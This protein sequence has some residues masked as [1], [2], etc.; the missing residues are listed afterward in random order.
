MHVT[1]TSDVIT[2]K[3]NKVQLL[4]IQEEGALNLKFY[5]CT[6]IRGS[7]VKRFSS[8]QTQNNAN[9]M[10]QVAGDIVGIKKICVC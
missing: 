5:S 8:V 9:D 10:R 6:I 4:Q 2:V 7:L 1:G 3:L